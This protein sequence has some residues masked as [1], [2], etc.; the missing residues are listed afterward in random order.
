MLGFGSATRVYVAVGT[1]DMRKGFE[2]LFGIV[3]DRLMIDPMTGH[4][5]VFCNA[6]PG[7]GTEQFTDPHHPTIQRSTESEPLSF[8]NRDCDW[9]GSRSMDQ[10]VFGHER[11]A[12]TGALICRKAC[13]RSCCARLRS[14]TSMTDP[15]N[16]IHIGSEDAGPRVAAIVS[17]VETC[18]RLKTDTFHKARAIL[19]LGILSR[20]SVS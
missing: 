12:F 7:D 8:A 11:G 9:S 4:V 20:L 3:R 6:C 18:R 13:S 15:T 10:G 2:G 1:T 14:V 5:F 19:T 16:W 17:V